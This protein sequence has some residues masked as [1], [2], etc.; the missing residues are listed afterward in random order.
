M[1]AQPTVAKV[2]DSPVQEVEVMNESEK[3]SF[4]TGSLRTVELASEHEIEEKTV[5]KK[6]ERSDARPPAIDCNTRIVVTKLDLN[7]P[8][9]SRSN[10]PK[11]S[12]RAVSR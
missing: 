3:N 8:V 12:P 4:R 10:L 11:N 1:I 9:R 7:S 5:D 2:D 6:E